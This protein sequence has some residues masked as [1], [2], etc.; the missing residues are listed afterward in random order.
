MKWPRC[1]GSSYSAP[2]KIPD[3]ISTFLKIV[4]YP[5]LF[6]NII[7]Y[8]SSFLYD[9]TSIVYFDTKSNK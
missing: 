4:I 7:I 1:M 9:V 5:H 3:I 8:N 6:I 2:E